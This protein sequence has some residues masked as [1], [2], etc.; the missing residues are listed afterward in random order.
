MDRPTPISDI[1]AWIYGRQHHQAGEDA[2]QLQAQFEKNLRYYR[3]LLASRLPAERSGAILDLPCGQGGM[4][5]TLKRLGYENVSG[6]DLDP[7]RLA[8]GRKLGLPVSEGNVFEVLERQP[9]AGVACILSMDFLEHVE[10]IDAVRFLELAHRKLAPGGR[11]LVRTPCADAPTGAS[12]IFND[13]THKWAATSG[14]LRWLLGAVGFESVEI[15]GEHPNAA[16]SRGA[17]RV[18]LFGLVRLLVRFGTLALGVENPR[19]LSPSMW[20][21]G[22]KPRV[23]GARSEPEASAGRNDG[24]AR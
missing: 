11:L 13:M 6:Y 21:L 7:H 4:V 3:A 1:D 12:H 22:C 10:K 20:G 23:G 17:L 16:M 24:P 5:Y 9:D 2:A 14:V 15:F 19:V 8:V 18:P